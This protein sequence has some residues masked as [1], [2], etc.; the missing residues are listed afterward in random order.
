VSPHDYHHLLRRWKALARSAG[1]RLQ[2]LAMAG[3]LPLFFIKTTAL[4]AEGGLYLSAGVHGDEPGATEALLAWA[5]GN[6]AR[7]HEMP[8]LI[9]PCLNPWGLE[10]NMRQDET[11]LDLNR[12]FHHTEH[13]V[14]A[15]VKRA[16][17][18]HRFAATVHLHEDYDA[19]GLY[20]YELTRGKDLW[21][22]ALIAAAGAAL[23]P[24][25]RARIDG[26]RAN[27][28]HIHRKVV[29]AHFSEIGFPEA[30]WLFSEHTGRSFTIETPSEFSL[31]ERVAAHRAVLEEIERH[32]SQ[33]TKNAGQ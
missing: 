4:G 23:P 33:T 30:I 3:E 31:A 20:L 17:A 13:A 22:R 1:V 27:R 8:L 26:S 7:L 9:F 24:D 12:H 21:G 10:R 32:L 11:G 5:E 25:P 29:P 19:E 28:G 15:A 6:A 14:I 16:A 18:P 2:P